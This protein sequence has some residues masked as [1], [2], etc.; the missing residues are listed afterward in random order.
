MLVVATFLLFQKAFMLGSYDLVERV[1]QASTRGPDWDASIYA[2]RGYWATALFVATLV[3]FALAAAAGTSV[4]RSAA[5]VR[6]KL[7]VAVGTLALFGA[8]VAHPPLAVSPWVV[9][10]LQLVQA[11]TGFSAHLQLTLFLAH[12]F[13]TALLVAASVALKVGTVVTRPTD[14]RGLVEAQLDV[15]NLL[16]LST[17][18]LIIGALGIGALHRLASSSS[19]PELREAI[20]VVGSASTVFASAFYSALLAATFAPAELLLRRAGSHL[21]RAKPAGEL[22][23]AREW[24][25][26]QGF[27]LSVTQSLGR[28]LAILSPLLAGLAQNIANLG[29]VS[30]AGP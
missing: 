29:A 23:S 22:G 12:L 17:A 5:P 9:Q 4:Y 19:A 27:D 20:H 8:I 13:A 6:L 26:A 2:A 10:E 21:A 11:L 28:I 15:R 18:W 30:G 25:R 16:G 7:G 14:V 1:V 3:S 24:L